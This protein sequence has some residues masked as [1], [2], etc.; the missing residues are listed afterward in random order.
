MNILITGGTGFIGKL[1]TEYLGRSG[2]TLFLTT[3]NTARPGGFIQWNSLTEEFPA[4]QLPPSLDG[5]INLMGENIANKRWTPG[6]KRKLED[7][8]IS[9]TEKLI[10]GLAA[11]PHEPS[12]FI[13]ASAIGYYPHNQQQAID[14]SVSK[15]EGFLSDLCHRWEQT[16]TLLPPSVRT[17]TVRIGV[18]LGTRGGML[19]KL[20]PIFKLG[21][22]GTIGAGEQMMS[23]IH[24][25]DL[26]RALQTIAED[27]SYR[28][29]FNL[30]APQAVS[31]R[32]FTKA[33][34][35]ALKRPTLFPVPPLALRLAM[36][37]MSTIALDGQRIV[38]KALEDRGFRFNYP[39]IDQALANL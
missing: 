21:L 36:G 11:R 12:F 22:G 20:L 31:N 37:E 7:S 25:E 27:E 14:E 18:V 29:V 30:V 10:R 33:L 24:R 1:L 2:H 4:R 13:S 17:A 32:E 26:V 6:Q 23:W 28:G 19:K 8:R 9:A 38:P 3:R 35:K 34:G 16:L 5:V 39:S 15:G